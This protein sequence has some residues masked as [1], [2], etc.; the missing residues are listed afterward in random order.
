AGLYDP[1]SNQWTTT[2]LPTQMFRLPSMTST[3]TGRNV[4]LAGVTLGINRRL[5]VASYDPVTDRWTMITPA[6]PAGHTPSYAAVLATSDRVIMWVP[7]T[8]VQL[9]RQSAF[10]F[11]TD[12][13]ALRGDG[14]WQD[15][16]GTWPQRQTIYEPAFTGTEILIPTSENRCVTPSCPISRIYPG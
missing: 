14:R 5:E 16:T 4:I 8:H 13:L 3:W 6:L 11:G 12:V 15:V 1:D 9:K 7:W 2:Q 10:R